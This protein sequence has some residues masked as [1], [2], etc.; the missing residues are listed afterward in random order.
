MKHLKCK[1]M[2]LTKFIMYICFVQTYA[3]NQMELFC[4]TSHAH[5]NV[6]IVFFCAF[7]IYDLHLQFVFICR[8]SCIQNTTIFLSIRFPRIM[9]GFMFSVLLMFWLFGFYFISNNLF[10]QFPDLIYIHKLLLIIIRL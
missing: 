4:W 6:H 8:N 1:F 9:N 10:I 5:F 7:Q 3:I 2:Q